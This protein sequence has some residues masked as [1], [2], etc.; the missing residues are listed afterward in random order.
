MQYN[1]GAIKLPFS[2]I[3]FAL[4]LPVKLSLFIFFI[5]FLYMFFAYLSIALSI[6]FSALRGDSDKISCLRSL[7]TTKQIKN[8]SKIFRSTTFAME[9]VKKIS[10][11]QILLFKY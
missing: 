5:S 2:N 10:K 9:K 8:K 11:S 6:V 7:K 4:V 1:F 3:G